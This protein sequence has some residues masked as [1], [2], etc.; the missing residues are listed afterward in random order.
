MEQ[1]VDYDVKL[2]KSDT[3]YIPR[4]LDLKSQLT[5]KSEITNHLGN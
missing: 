1:E 2:Q 5:F 4:A 3:L